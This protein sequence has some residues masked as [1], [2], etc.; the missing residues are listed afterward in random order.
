LD[1]SL[2]TEPFPNV[3]SAQAVNSFDRSLEKHSK[4]EAFRA[5]R[6]EASKMI[7]G[8]R[9]ITKC[10]CRDLVVDS[11]ALGLSRQGDKYRFYRALFKPEPT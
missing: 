10:P 5:P 7:P 6:V 4:G 2:T 9:V 1:L 3:T 8:S 11:G